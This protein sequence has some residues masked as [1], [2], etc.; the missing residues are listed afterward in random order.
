MSNFKQL[1]RD[2]LFDNGRNEVAQVKLARA[3]IENS[4]IDSDRGIRFTAYKAQGGMIVE[5]HFYDRIKDRNHRT[6][7]IITDDKDLGQEIG[8]IITMETLKI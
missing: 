8:K 5:T 4:D 1:I 6:L 7:H 3:G 2:W